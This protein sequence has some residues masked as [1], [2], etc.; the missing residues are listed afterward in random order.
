M[1]EINTLTESDD[2]EGKGTISPIFGE[3]YNHKY[4]T[5]EENSKSLINR[6]YSTEGKSTEN[7]KKKIF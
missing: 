2:Y 4:Q 6:T 3:D 1:Y 5:I 7:V